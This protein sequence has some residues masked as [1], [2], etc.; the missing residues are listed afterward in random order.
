MACSLP[1]NASL[2]D[3]DNSS[4]EH[5]FVK[6]YFKK[7]LYIVGTFYIPPNSKF[8]SY[9]TV[10]NIIENVSNFFPS[11]TL[12]IIGDLIYPLYFGVHSL[13]LGLPAIQTFVTKLR[14][15]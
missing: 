1:L 8:N 7:I 5:I 6:F 15:H 2:L 12:I 13:T 9:L 11:A 14:S 3:T 10:Y 4:V